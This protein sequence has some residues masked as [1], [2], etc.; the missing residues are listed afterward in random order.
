MSEFSFILT[1][2]FYGLAFFSMGL[3]VA[4]EGGQA[5]DLRLRRGL[6]P[7]AGFGLV[8]ATH[9][10]LEMF[11]RIAGYMDYHIDTP[12]FQGIR[13]AILAFSFLSLSAFGAYLLAPEHRA[14]KI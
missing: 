9:E 3:L 10:W 4:V 5:S 2:F 11:E 1:Y 6:R 12:L 8:H 13:L 14:F 7:L